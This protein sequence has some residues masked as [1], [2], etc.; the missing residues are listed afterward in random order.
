MASSKSQF[1]WNNFVDRSNSRLDGLSKA[2]LKPRR[3]YSLLGLSKGETFDTATEKCLEVSREKHWP[4]SRMAKLVL[5]MAAASCVGQFP[6][7]AWTD[8]MSEA[9]ALCTCNQSDDRSSVARSQTFVIRNAWILQIGAGAFLLPSV[10]PTFLAQPQPM[11]FGANLNSMALHFPSCEP[12]TD[13]ARTSTKRLASVPSGVDLHS[14]SEWIAYNA[15]HLSLIWVSLWVQVPHMNK[16]SSQ[17]L[18]CWQLNVDKLST[19]SPKI[20]RV[21]SLQSF[22]NASPEHS[23]M[24]L[25]ELE[26]G[27]AFSRFMFRRSQKQNIKLLQVQKG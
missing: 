16:T 22:D 4:G 17:W 12:R 26:Y 20:E 21:P 15:Q 19:V 18:V 2:W 14:V 6:S 23:N 25:C 1:L 7:F 13:L 5:S 11:T 10:Q 27:T 8:Q 24:P 9:V 3:I